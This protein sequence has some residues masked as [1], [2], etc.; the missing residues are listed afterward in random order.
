MTFLKIILVLSVLLYILVPTNNPFVLVLILAVVAFSFHHWEEDI[1]AFL[2][3]RTIT[4]PYRYEKRVFLNG[5]ANSHECIEVHG[6]KY[7]VY[8]Y[9][10]EKTNSLLHRK[11]CN[12]LIEDKR[13]ATEKEIDVYDYHMAK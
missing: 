9:I 8:T 4:Y 12:M 6:G 13:E 1:R 3:Y 11:L 7:Y 5:D 2:G 10:Q